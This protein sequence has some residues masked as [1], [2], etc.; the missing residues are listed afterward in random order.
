MTGKTGQYSQNWTGRAKIVSGPHAARAATAKAAA[1]AANAY[2]RATD[3]NAAVKAKAAAWAAYVRAKAAYATEATDA[4]ATAHAAAW[5]AYDAYTTDAKAAHAARVAATDAYADAAW[6]AYTDAKA[7]YATDATY[8]N[9]AVK[10][11]AWAA[12]ATA[13]ADAR[14]ADPGGLRDGGIWTAGTAVYVAA[15]VASVAYLYATLTAVCVAAAVAIVA[16]VKVAA[17]AARPN[18]TATLVVS[19]AATATT[20]AAVVAYVELLGITTE[21]LA[22]GFAL[23]V[24]AAAMVGATFS[25]KVT[26]A[27]YTWVDTVAYGVFLVAAIIFAMATV[28]TV[29]GVICLLAIAAKGL[30]IALAAT[31]RITNAY[32][33]YAARAAIGVAVALGAALLIGGLSE[34][35]SA[36][37]CQRPA[38]F[39]EAPQ[40]RDARVTS[41]KAANASVVVKAAA[42]ADTDAVRTPDAA[43]WANAAYNYTRADAVRAT[44]A[45]NARVAKAAANVVWVRADAAYADVDAETAWASAVAKADAAKADADAARAAKAKADAMV[46]AARVTAAYARY[47]AAYAANA[48]NA[49]AVANAADAAY[50]RAAADAKAARAAADAAAR[51]GSNP[52][53]RSR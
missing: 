49:D 42:R 18:P 48:A 44:D 50:V 6:V 24:W 1:D 53:M 46:A 51:A 38:V 16:V 37:T 17:W 11:A 28:T 47:A 2:V 41:A 22:V 9:A 39:V 20:V 14:A 12:Y 8:A 21:H 34:S 30:D 23:A 10:A 35:M 13:D 3:S 45:A 29:P 19:M 43:A 25:A 15:I 27:E 5:A 31:A 33:R 32:A 52:R 40:T 26:D 4:N 7:A 36:T